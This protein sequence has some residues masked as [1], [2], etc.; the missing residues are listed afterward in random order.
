MPFISILIFEIFFEPP[1][2]LHYI[3]MNVWM[4]N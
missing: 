1:I 4:G 3:F 2:I